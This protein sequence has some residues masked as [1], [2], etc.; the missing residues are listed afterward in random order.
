LP[1]RRERFFRAALSSFATPFVAPGPF[2]FF[3]FFR[4]RRWLV[5]GVG[6]DEQRSQVPQGG[7]SSSPNQRLK[8]TLRHPLESA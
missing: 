5:P 3:A 6:A 8:M 7:G 4:L 1:P 2:R